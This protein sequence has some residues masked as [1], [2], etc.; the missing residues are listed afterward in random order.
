[1]IPIFRE[2]I[3]NW[4]AVE[5]NFR[6]LKTVNL[7]HI[8]LPTDAEIFLENHI[9]SLKRSSL[10]R[11]ARNLNSLLSPTYDVSKNICDVQEE[12]KDGNIID[13]VEEVNIY[14]LNNSVNFCY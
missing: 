7:K 12:L 6:K 3:S 2:E 4:A 10:I 9:S 1:M 11:S 5:S 8:F 13:N 14:D